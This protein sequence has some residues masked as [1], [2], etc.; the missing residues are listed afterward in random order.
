MMTC[1]LF[2]G[3]GNQLFQIATTLAV[4]WEH[5]DTAIFDL[6][7][8][9][10]LSQGTPAREYQGTI[11]RNLLTGKLP[12]SKFIYIEGEKYCPIPYHQDMELRGSF[13]SERY[14]NN[15]RDRLLE[16]FAPTEKALAIAAYKYP[17]IKQYCAIHVRR[18]D[19]QNRPK[20]HP[21][22]GS[23]LGAT[24]CWA[25]S[26]PS[27]E[28]TS[29]RLHPLFASGNPTGATPLLPIDYYDLAISQFEPDRKFLVF[30]DDP[31]WCIKTFTNENR[32]T[33]VANRADY[34]DLYLMS[35]CEHHI[36][37]NSTFSWWGAYLSKNPD[38][39]VITPNRILHNKSAL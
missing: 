18:G 19:Y 15:Y 24:H 8:H 26:P 36:I 30:S 29:A 33:I 7:R 31:N 10:E 4:A 39:I 13:Q 16:L 28:E 25:G 21:M 2:G 3:L 14:F 20:T 9:F 1:Q 32:F 27:A 35:M 34:I 22:L 6:D 12:Q 5:N 23:L 17:D 11:Y 37:A 38:K